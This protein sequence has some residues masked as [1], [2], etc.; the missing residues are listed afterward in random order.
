MNEMA[1]SYET[2]IIGG[3]QAG[4][5]TGYYLQQQGRDFVI[6]DANERVGHS[7]R[8]RWDSLHLFTPARYNGLPGMPFP[9]PAHYL[10]TKDDM[11][12]YLEAYAERFELPVRTRVRV[13]RL[14]KQGNQF[15]LTADAP[16]TGSGRALRFTAENVVVATGFYHCPRI[17]AFACELDA[18]IVQLHSSEYQRPSQLQEG[19][20][21]VVGAANSGA[22]IALELS[23]SRQTWLSGRHPGSEPTR[24]GSALARLV[25]PV[26]WFVFSYVLSVKTPIGRKLRPKLLKMG[27]LPLAASDPPICRRPG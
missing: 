17:P 20:V 13:D 21:L 26:M 2:I 3:G 11:A 24:P 8:K 7:W 25:V 14:S 15:V 19:S 27:G 4:L 22:E 10:P 9:A 23:Q 18:N 1:H 12:D 16:S 6:L 5:A